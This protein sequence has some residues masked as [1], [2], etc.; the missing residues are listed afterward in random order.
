MLRHSL[1][2]IPN[3]MDILRRTLPLLKD[4]GIL[5]IETPNQKSLK[6]ALVGKRIRGNRYLGHLYP[7]THIH[8]FS[9]RTYQAVGKALGLTMLRHITYSPADPNWVYTSLYTRRGLIPMIHRFSAQ[10]GMGENIAVFFRKAP[11]ANKA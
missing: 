4:D 6:C 9:L 11:A 1:E 7:P 10:A 8:A 3:F 2:H 5:C